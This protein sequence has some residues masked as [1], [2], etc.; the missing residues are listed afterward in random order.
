MSY[1]L[2][3]DFDPNTG[4]V[5]N[6]TFDPKTGEII[7]DSIDT[8]LILKFFNSAVKN[9]KTILLYLILKIFTIQKP[10]TLHRHG[11]ANQY[12]QNI[13]RQKKAHIYLAL[14]T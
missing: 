6:Q 2:S 5:K 11:M 4:K 9:P 3:Q 13:I 8:S 1:P 14:Q 7:A 12:P 10:S